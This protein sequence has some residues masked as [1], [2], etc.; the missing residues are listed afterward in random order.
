MNW[1]E[2]LPKRSRRGSRPRCLLFMNGDRRS[3]ASRLTALAGLANVSVGEDDFWMPQGLPGHKIDGAWDL[4]PTREAKLGEDKGFLS[5]EQR[6]IV[7]KWWLEVVPGNT[8]NWDIASTCRI[9]GT[10]GV[11]LVEAKAHDRELSSSGKQYQTRP[12]GQKNHQK[13]G[14]AIQQT[15][16]DLNRLY[17][18]WNLSRDSHYQLCNRFAWTWKL[19]SLGVP[20]VLIYLGF[21][22]AEDMADR[23]NPIENHE[24]W[25]RIV[26]AHSQGLVPETVWDTWLRVNQTPMGILLR[27][28]EL[29]L[30]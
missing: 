2:A 26:K 5:P 7:T 22:H 29:K 12:N 25:S 3:V 8:P 28:V 30:G 10:R 23:G 20:V 9:N 19:V 11:L 16:A 27:T 21:L 24:V 17:P 15:N 13:I 1:L 18:S 14:I 6:S 4:L